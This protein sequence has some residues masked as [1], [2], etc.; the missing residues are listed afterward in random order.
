[1][2]QPMFGT[3]LLLQVGD[4]VATTRVIVDKSNAWEA[5]TFIGYVTH[6]PIRVAGGWSVE[7]DTGTW[8]FRNTQTL[9]I[10]EP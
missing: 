10:W 4:G 6:R 2:E 3:A 1:M 9:A 7:C 5:Q 8:V